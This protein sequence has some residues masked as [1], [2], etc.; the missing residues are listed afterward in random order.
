MYDEGMKSVLFV[1]VSL[2]IAFFS[3]QPVSADSAQAYQDYIYQ[4]DQYRN[5][6][7]EY[8][9]AKNEYDKFKTLTSETAALEKA[10]NMMQWRDILL[11]SYLI[12]LNEKMKESPGIEDADRALYQTLI[13]NENTFLL[14]HSELIPSVASIKD[15]TK[16][17][18]QLESHYLV[19]QTS[20]RQIILGIGM[21]KLNYLS[22][23]VQQATLDAG[24]ILAESRPYITSSSQSVADR[25]SV[26]ING[27]QLLY[28]QKMNQVRTE[29]SSLDER[30]VRQLDLTVAK[31]QKEMGEA[32]TYL[33]EAV[34][35][36]QELMNILLYTN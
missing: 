25:W 24:S 18:Q 3:P 6:N 13:D 26:S 32:R 10:I 27:K 15:A 30:D 1:L 2:F 28:T 4:L 36:I 19:L 17:S 7:N 16:V 14:T 21:G 12:Y 20:V 8:K 29:I 23:Q 31:I 5:A 33:S 9:I 34:S 11:R 22:Q 35:Y